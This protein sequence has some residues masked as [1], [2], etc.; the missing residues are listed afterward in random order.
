MENKL[1]YIFILSFFQWSLYAQESAN[2]EYLKSNPFQQEF[3]SSHWKKIKRTMVRE[4]KGNGKSKEEEFSRSDF[5]NNS[6]DASYYEYEEESFSGEYAKNNGENDYEYEEERL[7]YKSDEGEGYANYNRK[8]RD[9]E[10]G[11]YFTKNKEY[12]ERRVREKNNKSYNGEGMG[13]LGSIF[14][15]SLL[16]LFLGAIIYLLFINV[17]ISDEG[18][19]VTSVEIDKA[20]IEIPKTELELMLEKA[21]NNNDLY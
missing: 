5:E 20:P 16:A 18:K 8:E 2:Q 12:K 17:T 11:E 9:L 7:N 13:A 4:A 3:S 14:L 10:T 6:Q 1:I 21:I 19:K 15:Y